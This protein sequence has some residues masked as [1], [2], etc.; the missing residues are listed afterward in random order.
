MIFY[1]A[2]KGVWCLFRP[3]HVF[4][5]VHLSRVEWQVPVTLF[6]SLIAW[7]EANAFIKLY[8]LHSLTKLSKCIMQEDN[9]HDE[10]IRGKQSTVAK[11]TKGGCIYQER[12][13]G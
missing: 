11:Y 12:Y 8:G 10:Y 6:M 3:R 1:P 5:S 7:V 2:F 13:E 4:L 9:E